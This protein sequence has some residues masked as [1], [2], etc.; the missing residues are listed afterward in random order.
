MIVSPIAA[1]VLVAIMNNK[2]DFALARE[3][4][5]CRRTTDRHRSSRPDTIAA[6]R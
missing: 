4:H 6:V 3:E 1:R 5:W 2:L